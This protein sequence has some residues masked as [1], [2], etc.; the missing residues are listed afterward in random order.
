MLVNG[1][2]SLLRCLRIYST[3]LQGFSMHSLFAIKKSQWHIQLEALNSISHFFLVDDCYFMLFFDPST[4]RRFSFSLIFVFFSFEKFF[5]SMFFFKFSY[6]Y[7]HRIFIDK[8]SCFFPPFSG[9]IGREHTC[10]VSVI[11]ICVYSCVVKCSR[12][13]IFS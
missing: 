3:D 13:H 10:I 2:F 6:L 11:Y 8:Y 7:E 4:V 5:L 9:K 12:L 1:I